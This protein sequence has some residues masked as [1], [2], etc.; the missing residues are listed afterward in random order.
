MMFRYFSILLFLVSWPLFPRDMKEIIASIPNPRLQNSWIVD[1]PGVLGP[2]KAEMDSMIDK[3]EKGN[4]SEIAVVILTSI[5]D[6][7]PKDFA[8]ELFNTW[9]IGK[10]GKD[11]GLLILHVMDQRRIE[12]ETGYGTEAVLPDAK[13]KWIIDDVA[14]P[15]FKKGSFA[16]GHYEMLRAAIRG[17]ENPEM[18]HEALVTGLISVPGQSVQE[19]D[20]S[21]HE[22]AEVSEPVISSDSSIPLYMG[23]IG[24]GGMLAWALGFLAIRPRRNPRAAYRFI[25]KSRI[26]QYLLGL[27]LGAAPGVWELN[28]FESFFSFFIGLPLLSF[29]TYRARSKMISYTRS[30]P[31]VCPKC[32]KTMNKLSED[33]DDI[34][35]E[36]GQI[37]EE[38]IESID[39]DVWECSCG[40]QIVEDYAD[41][42]SSYDKCPSCS[43]KTWGVEK[44]VVVTAATTSHSGLKNVYYRCKNCSHNKM[45][46]VVIPRKSSSSSGGR[47]GGGSFGGGRS[48]GGGAGGSY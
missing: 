41:P 18:G 44:T 20:I 23:G 15:F 14:I 42:F 22:M 25:E 29:L 43:Y 32:G 27:D 40:N 47:G 3:L 10:K 13:C 38:K 5:D 31:R 16:D 33:K 37:T 8:V 24:L 34:A 28:Q 35:L 39:Y 1:E 21:G 7:V 9:G 2:R 36:K 17:I 4:G 30:V 19:V 48:G 6:N 12:I 11:N 46:E 26:P 45:E